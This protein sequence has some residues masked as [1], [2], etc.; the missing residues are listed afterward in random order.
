MITAARRVPFTLGF[1]VV[2][3]LTGLL[4][5]SVRSGPSGGLRDQVGTGAGPIAAGHWWSPLSALLF[6]GGLTGYLGVTV[7][8]G[9]VCGVA[10]YQLGTRWVVA[11]F[12]VT[13]VAG[14]LL[15]VGVIRLGGL[16]GDWWAADLADGVVITPSGGVLGVAMLASARAPALWRRRVRFGVVFAVLLA[17]L[18]LGS[19]A[20]LV[21]LCAALT[22]LVSGVIVFGRARTR[23]L[24]AEGRL[25]V[26]VVVAASALGPLLATVA[27]TADGPL[28]VLQSLFFADQLDPADVRVTCADPAANLLCQQQLAAL[29]LSGAG[30]AVLSVVPVLL[31]LLMAEG[32]RRGR[33]FAWWGA[34]ALNTGLAVLGGFLVI[35]NLDYGGAPANLHDWIAETAPLSEP[36]VIVGLLLAT[37]RRF[38]VSAPRGTYPRFLGFVAATAV[39]CSAACLLATFLLRRDFDGS[40]TFAQLAAGLPMRFLPPGYLA[41]YPIQHLPH[42][43][44]AGLFHQWTGPVFWLVVI[45]GCLA[46]FLRARVVRR[47]ADA[48]E[49]RALLRRFGGTS[50]SH[51]IT[52]RGNDYWFSADRQTVL[53]Y[54]VI[55]GVA[56]TTG[57]PVGP[58]E[59]RV[60]AVD[61]FA[62][63]CA[64]NGW[65]PCCYAITDE[66]CA[67]LATARWRTVQ[68]AD[69]ALLI[70]QELEFRGKKW[71]DVRSARNKARTLGVRAE[72]IDYPAADPAIARQ[73]RAICRDWAAGKGLPEMGF[74]LGT[75][76]ELT[77]PDVRCLIAVDES[78]VVHGITSWLPFRGGD[79]AI[80]GWTLDLMR[81]KADAFAGVMEF[82]I[83]AMAV[84]ARTED[85]AVLSLSGAPLA[86]LRRGAARPLDKL[87]DLA[88]RVLEP[89]YGFR[90]LAAFKT[91]FQPQHVALHLAY[92]DP[93]ALPAIGNAI[94]RA[95]LSSAT[96]GQY[97]RLVR[98]VVF[99]RANLRNVAPAPEDATS[100]RV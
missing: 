83:A 86:G 17:A 92:P 14:V 30:A 27:Q 11:G 31:L 32:L 43:P 69:E 51:M 93:A 67:Q 65:I 42:T 52:W 48:T 71:Q 39:V 18:Y 94:T 46:T 3:W 2:F 1:L 57:E 68:V 7:L 24:A 22:G 54:R 49:A 90:S 8:A 80:V 26:A 9:V 36:V 75:L 78:G 58:A 28:S 85:V 40:P 97:A 38:P 37:F 99:R 87:L 25:L 72:L 29:R 81:R 23:P 35:G 15:A 55:F 53:A 77:D 4:S 13:Q 19:A 45:A 62:R 16:L 21:R 100:L 56:L 73:V 96:T 91:K 95:Y 59:H 50:L 84:R 98:A 76:A 66:L 6:T 44:L 82:L 33:R 12:V 79:G 70:P 34:L 63:F 64:G 61:E 10:E 89:V 60:A 41:P 20:D 5:G 88:G 74:T 47:D